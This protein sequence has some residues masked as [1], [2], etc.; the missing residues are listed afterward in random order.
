MDSRTLSADTGDK[1]TPKTTDSRGGRLRIAAILA[2]ALAALLLT[3]GTAEANTIASP[4]QTGDVGQWTSVALDS[5]GYPVVSYYDVT[6]GDLK[7]LHCGNANCT[8]GNSTASP[9]TGG[10]VGRW[11]SI[12][13]DSSGYPVVSYYDVTNADLKLLHCG[14]ATC[15]SGNSITSPDTGGDVGQWNSIVLDS[16]GNPVVSYYDATNIDLK[17]LHCGDA[18][19]TSGNSITSPDT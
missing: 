19:C 8:S 12:A 4:D 11:T 1:T 3:D 16:S 10:D 13:L 14:N 18:T 15:T 17:V 6:N 7:V 9:D 5:S 2:L